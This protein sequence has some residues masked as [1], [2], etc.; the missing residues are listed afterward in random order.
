MKISQ[1]VKFR[2]VNPSEA[3][4][5][6]LAA[7][8]M[9]SHLFHHVTTK[10]ETPANPS[11][12]PVQTLAREEHDILD[13]NASHDHVLACAA[14]HTSPRPPNPTVTHHSIEETPP[15]PN[16]HPLGNRLG[17]LCPGGDAE[18]GEFLGGRGRGRECQ[19]VHLDGDIIVLVESDARGVLGRL[20]KLLDLSVLAR[21]VPPAASAAAA[22]APAVQEG[23]WSAISA[24]YAREGSRKISET[25]Q[26]NAG[27]AM[28]NLAGIP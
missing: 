3:R 28:S 11:T 14:P 10:P 24:R 15:P 1:F 26:G 17:N 13:E 4:S 9:D 12:P 19:G 8:G 22:A 5:P 2:K 16:S 25:L 18:L 6:V 21:A 7:S 20:E 23:A 27:D